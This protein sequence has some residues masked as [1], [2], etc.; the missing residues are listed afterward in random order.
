MLLE[1]QIQLPFTALHVIAC[2]RLIHSQFIR[3]QRSVSLN[4]V[5]QRM[6]ARSHQSL[7][8]EP[9]KALFVVRSHARSFICT[10]FNFQNEW[11][12]LKQEFWCTEVRDQ[13][14]S[15]ADVCV[16][17]CRKKCAWYLWWYIQWINIAREH[18]RRTKYIHLSLVPCIWESESIKVYNHLVQL[19]CLVRWV[20]RI[21][22]AEFRVHNLR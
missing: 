20:F 13:V 7:M 3:P 18:S 15:T 4:I 1:R 8:H 6:H 11:C 9:A 12:K 5:E 21:V 19:P 16:C 2:I 10:V 17:V 14:L 22:E